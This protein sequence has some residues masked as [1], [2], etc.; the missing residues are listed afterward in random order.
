M[1]SSVLRR[2]DPFPRNRNVVTGKKRVSV[3]QWRLC[4]LFCLFSCHASLASKLC[5]SFLLTTYFVVTTLL[6]GSPSLLFYIVKDTN[7]VFLNRTD[8]RFFHMIRLF[9]FLSLFT[10]DRLFRPF[11]LFWS[12][13]L[14]IQ[15]SPL[16][17]SSPYSILGPL[18]SPSMDCDLCITLR[19]SRGSSNLWMVVSFW[20]ESLGETKD[21]ELHTR[22][23]FLGYDIASLQPLG[24]LQGS[25]V[26]AQ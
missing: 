20:I 11:L 16:R 3:I 2:T 17:F 19:Y 14:V 15:T 18:F 22:I 13:L 12:I 5:T 21:Q 25:Q 23:C 10:G 26:L 8:V 4:F 1:M 24:Y 7:D 9:L 6:E